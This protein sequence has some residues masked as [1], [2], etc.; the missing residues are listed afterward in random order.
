MS[1]IKLLFGVFVYINFAFF[2]LILLKPMHEL[3]PYISDWLYLNI[4]ILSA[5]LS[6]TYYKN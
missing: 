5:I 1:I 2:Y 6:M 3:L 4:L